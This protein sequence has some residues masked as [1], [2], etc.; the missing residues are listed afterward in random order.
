MTPAHALTVLLARWKMLVGGVAIGIFVAAIYIFVTPKIYQSTASLVLNVR[1]PETVGIQSVAEQ[2][3]PDYLITQEDILKSS[4]V[5]RRV[6]EATGV[7]TEVSL[8]RQWGW[9]PADGA[10]ADYMAK[11]LGNSLSIR[12]SAVNSRVIELGYSSPDREFAALMANAFAEAYADVM[13]DLQ[14]EPARRTVD[15][16]SQQLASLSLQLGSAQKKLAARQKELGIV[17]STDSD[18]D[19]VRLDALASQLAIAQAE[20]A[21]VGGRS[22][23]GA[24]PD[25]MASPVVQGLQGE[26]AKLEG[27]RRQLS[28]VAGP[29]N[30]DYQQ[31]TNQLS[32]LRSQ[33]A[34]QQGLIR[35]S[36]AASSQQTG[37]ALSDLSSSIAQQRQR[38]IEA[39]AARAEVAVLDQDVNNIKTL[40]DQVAARRAQ[41]KVLGDVGQTNV[42]I[43]TRAMPSRRPVWPRKGRIL[44]FGIVGGFVL[45]VV[46]A[47]GIE[48]ADRRLRGSS[49]FEHWLG[50]PDLGSIQMGERRQR[51]LSGGVA[52][53][54]SYG[55]NQR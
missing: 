26:I 43:L 31:I 41:L 14:T 8:A 12:S 30:P 13:V 38:V 18:A 54:I 46:I 42:S 51:R 50:I 22:K 21:A 44:V 2:L 45:G 32:E 25:A 6:A 53:L 34:T 3:S 29:N 33:V 37:S 52:G 39:R 10:V 49:E 17:S 36:V 55:R 1:A 19:T 4:R 5:A 48:L 9:T 20:G 15:S 23:A 7:A 47:I 35:Q 40:Y 11:Q 28:T 27:Q 24:L 16:Y